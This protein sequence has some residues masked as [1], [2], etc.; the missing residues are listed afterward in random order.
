MH[1]LRHWYASSLLAG[2]A[3]PVEVSAYLGHSDVAF[4]LRTYAHLMPSSEDRAREAIEAA[5]A[6]A[7]E[8]VNGGAADA[9]LHQRYISGS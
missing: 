5:F 3:S 9:A 8:A 6:A 2:G 7:R 4:T 1:G